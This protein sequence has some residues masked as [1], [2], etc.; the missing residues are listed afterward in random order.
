[1]TAGILLTFFALLVVAAFMASRGLPSAVA[2]LAAVCATTLFFI[3]FACFG[4][5][6]LAGWLYHFLALGLLLYLVYAFFL[7]KKPLPSLGLGFWLFAALGLFIIILFWVRQP[8]FLSW[9]E[10]STWG[11]STKLLK[12][13]NELY[14]TAPVGWPWPAT[15]PP[16]LMC[17]AYFMQFWGSGFSEWQT[18]AAYDILLFAVVAALLLPFEKKQWSIAIP[19][20][21]IGLLTPFMFAHYSEPQRLSNVY[22]DSMG[23]IPMAMLFAGALAC[24]YG[25]GKKGAKALLPVCLALPVLALSRDMVGIALALVV[26]ALIFADRL[27]A[28][29]GEKTSLLK[30]FGYALRGLLAT[31]GS[32]MAGFLGWS[33]YVSAALGVNRTNL[34]GANNVS[35]LQ[36]PLQFFGQFFAAEKSELFLQVMQGTAEAPGMP[37]MFFFLRLTLLGSGFVVMAL[38]L[39]LL[40]AAALITTDAALRR[41]SILFGVFS[42][43]GFL[44]Y[45]LF[46]AMYYI[47]IFRADQVF[48]SY[49]RYVYPY[50]LACFVTSVV[51]LA[52][53]AR[54]SRFVVEGKAAVL[55][56]CAVLCLRYVQVFPASYSVVGFHT[57]EFNARRDFARQVEQVTQ[58]LP[59]SSK[60]FIVSTDDDGLRWFM[61]CYQFLPYQ[62]DYSFGGGTDPETGQFFAKETDADGNAVVTLYPPQA[63]ASYLLEKGCD[64]VL[65]DF[66]GDS[67]TQ[68]YGALFADGLAQHRQTGQL[69]LYSVQQT[70]NGVTLQPVAAV[71]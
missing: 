39:V 34:G 54:S 17:F 8:M 42:Q 69:V 44:A 51:F 64:Y 13:Y 61:Y 50:Y 15:Q 24:Y 10:F 57:E 41:S 16:A 31:G 12:L 40:A 52:S 62:L 4:L 35:M 63:W 7:K 66:A 67:F 1:M 2:P 19:V 37:H 38:C 48:A 25:G 3:A 14:T 20:A 65:V 29:F 28:K 71:Q 26:A 22:L 55:L 60:T 56:L 59:L 58:N 70:Q 30:R 45:Y 68:Q 43:L 36:M 5:L 23:D 47:Y 11:T 18:Y 9:D 32:A 33:A 49:E 6:S 46:L 53:A 27:F 21:L